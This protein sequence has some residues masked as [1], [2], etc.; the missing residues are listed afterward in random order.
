MFCIISPCYSFYNN[1]FQRSTYY[2]LFLSILYRRWLGLNLPDSLP[3]FVFCIISPYYTFYNNK[4][5]RSTTTYYSL[6]LSILYM[7]WSNSQATAELSEAAEPPLRW[8]LSS[9]LWVCCLLQTLW[10]ALFGWEPRFSGDYL[11]G[12][13][14]KTAFVARLAPPVI[15]ATETQPV[16][17]KWG[18]GQ[19]GYWRNP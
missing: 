17:H 2:S 7:T 14:E 10:S 16:D 9:E 3:L 15:P 1:K 11:A 4:F 12:K 8:A 13:S 19:V 18:N 6:F 5:Q